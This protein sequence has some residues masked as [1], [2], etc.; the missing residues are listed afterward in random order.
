MGT[1]NKLSQYYDQKFGT[2]TISRGQHKGEKALFSW[3][4]TADCTGETCP[5]FG[6]CEYEKVGK[7]KAMTL[8]LKGVTNVVIGEHLDDLTEAQLFRIGM[9][10]VPLYRTLVKMKIEELGVTRII[11]S[12]DKGKLSAHPIYKEMREQIKL[13]ELMWKTIGLHDIACATPLPDEG[14]LSGKGGSYYDKMEREALQEQ[15]TRNN[16]LRSVK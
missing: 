7:C 12:D 15:S 10:M 14:L 3:D 6:I 1:R 8:Y 4:I 11:S 2:L 9:H 16:R 5:A 13:I